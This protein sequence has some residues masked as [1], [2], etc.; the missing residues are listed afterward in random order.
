M[1]NDLFK[2][3]VFYRSIRIII[4]SV[5]L[6]FNSNDPFIKGVPKNMK[7]GRCLGDVKRI[8]R[9]KEKKYLKKKILKIIERYI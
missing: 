4:I 2:H 9:K 5:L 3:R 8:F 1:V 6:T 7:L